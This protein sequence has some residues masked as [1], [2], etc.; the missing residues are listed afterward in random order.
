MYHPE[1]TDFC[2]AD[3]T[4]LAC[5]H[6]ESDDCVCDVTYGLHIHA[7]FDCGHQTTLGAWWD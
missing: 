7:C 5:P 1:G 6:C 2:Q 4:Y 3:N